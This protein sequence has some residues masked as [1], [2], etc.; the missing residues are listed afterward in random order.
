MSSRALS[1]RGKQII[2]FDAPSSGT[3]ANQGTESTGI[4]ILGTITGNVTDNGNGTHGFVRAP[5]GKFTN[6]DAPGADPVVACTCPFSINNFG[7]IA[8]FYGDTNSV[9]HAFL[10]SPNGNIAAFDASEAGTGAGQGTYPVNV[11]DLGVVVGFYLDGNNVAHGFLRVPEGKLTTFDAPGA[12]TIASDSNG[13]FA[14]GMDDFGVVAGY[15]NDANLVSH[16]FLRTPDGKFTTFDA[17]G[18]DINPADSLGTLVSGINA[19]GVIGGSFYDVNLVEHGF[20]RSP[21]GSFVIFEAPGA[22]T[23]AYDGTNVNAIN[24]EGATTGYIEDVN[25]EA[26]PFVRTANGKATTFSIPGQL[27]LPGSGI[28]AAGEAINAFGVVAGRWRDVNNV[29]H[30]FLRIP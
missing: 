29:L 4:N 27:E 13:T 6:F 11:N 3:G 8:G 28:G 2:P 12:G 1:L 17:P 24:L 9:A 16:G 25:D 7:V 15:Y 5:D 18:A 10:R 19:L 20:S 26:H 23:S 14:Y 22:G 30:G 21:L